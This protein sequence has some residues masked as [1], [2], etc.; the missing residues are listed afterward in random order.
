MRISLSHRAGT[1]YEED[2]VRNQSFR[3]WQQGTG[4]CSHGIINGDTRSR[5]LQQIVAKLNCG[6][7]LMTYKILVYHQMDIE[8]AGKTWFKT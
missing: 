5:D 8:F 4:E 6:N 1:V 2:S 3:F 7:G